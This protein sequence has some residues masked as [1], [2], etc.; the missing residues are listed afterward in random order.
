M[1]LA[2]LSP[3]TC[4]NWYVSVCA[5]SVFVFKVGIKLERIPSF[6]ILLLI[7]LLS[8]FILTLIVKEIFVLL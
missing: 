2:S 4:L 5:P 3:K 7:E 1:F 6:I 8:N